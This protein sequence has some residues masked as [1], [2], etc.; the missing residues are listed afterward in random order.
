MNSPGTGT[1]WSDMAPRKD[2]ASPGQ[3]PRPNRPQLVE[4]QA[5]RTYLWCACGKS[6]RQPFCDG[7]HK[8]T[9]VRPLPWKA[10]ETVEK[11]FCGCKRT[12]TPPFCDGTHN[13]VSASRGASAAAAHPDVM[14]A[15][16]EPV[17][18]NARRAELDNGCYVFRPTVESLAPAGGVR[19]RQVIGTADGARHLSLFLVMVDAGTTSAAF[20]YPGSDVAGFVQSGRGTVHIG[21]RSFA[22]GPEAG[23]CIRPGE[24]FRM[25]NEG[26]ERMMLVLAVCPPCADP[27]VRETQTPRF[28]PSLPERVEAA[29][30]EREESMGDRFF[31]VL[32]G[33]RTHGTPV[34]QFIG[35]IPRSRAP[36]HRHIYEEAILILEGEGFLWTDTSKA[37][38]RPGDVIFLPLKQMH[39]LE[40]TSP[41]G[42]RLMG[43]FFP[44]MSPAVNY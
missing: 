36:H 19:M 5:G 18:G 34:T 30:S 29:S 26:A 11:L 31:Q 44:S 1:C 14:Q 42:M 38:V 25:I 4:V 43:V 13:R 16:F 3:T 17:A 35:R 32:I 8:G 27:P 10:E 6:A 39:S 41:G 20:E 33:E 15:A 40:C 37:P 21:R 23:I 28:D 12:G 2:P 24:S 22:V 9:D 7:S